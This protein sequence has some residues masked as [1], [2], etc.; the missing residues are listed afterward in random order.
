IANIE[1]AIVS[2]PENLWGGFGL[3]M[4]VVET[5]VEAGVDVFTGGNHSWDAPNP[6]MVMAHPQVLCPANIT[7]D[8]PGRG[9]CTL[10]VK[11]ETVVV[12]N[13]IGATAAGKRYQTQ[14]PFECYQ[15]QA[16]SFPPN[17]QV[18]ID[19]HA[20][21]PIEKWSL[22]R[23]LDGQVTAIMGTH[24]HEPTLNLHRLPQG[25][26][27]VADVGMNGP[28]GGILGMG[29]RYF[30]EKEQQPDAHVDFDLAPGAIQLGAIA[31]D[32]ETG[33]IWRL[34]PF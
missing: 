6:E 3:S 20:N 8:L 31:F 23:T 26:F 4:A 33:E 24:T 14:R 2:H 15:K 27:F 11:D 9:H 21:T 30:I 28:A 22:A 16:P 25:T 29:D 17:A 19:Y 34:R 7:T 10:T 12:L 13:L 1:N 5:L 18:L 32:T